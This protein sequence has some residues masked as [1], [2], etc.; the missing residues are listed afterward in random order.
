M[1]KKDLS[2]RRPLTLPFIVLAA[3][4]AAF[5]TVAVAISRSEKT[6]GAMPGRTATKATHP[7]VAVL[8]GKIVF[9]DANAQ[10][11]EFLAYYRSIEL[12]P[13]Q[14]EIKK[15]ALE[16]MPAACCRDSSAY[17]CCCSCNLSKTLW[18]LSNLAISKYGASAK[19]VQ[20]IAQSWL[21]YV[22]PTTG[23]RGDSCYTGGCGNPAH[24]G[25]CAGMEESKL[26]V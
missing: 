7:A 5:V 4:L 21:S 17:T 23:F 22:N 9:R 16:P 13:Q 26:D 24:R 6:H 18:G 3:V 15:A 2:K 19:E 25:G 11:K 14:E 1:Q 12:T 10:A 20:Q 8:G